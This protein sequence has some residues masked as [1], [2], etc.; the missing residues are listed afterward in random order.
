M[1]TDIDKRHRER[2]AEKARE[3]GRSTPSTSLKPLGSH[4]ASPFQQ[5][6][7]DPDAM[8]ISAGTSGSGNGK[9]REDWRK[10]LHSKCYSCGSDEHTIAKGYP[11]K[12][13][14]CQWCKKA[15][16]TSAVCMTRYLGQPRNDGPSQPQAVHA[17]IIPEASGSSS[18]SS[19]S[20][21]GAISEDVAAMVRQ[22]TEL[23]KALTEMRGDFS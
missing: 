6:S 10:A 8:D 12:R 4:Q 1:A 23:N 20:A 17:S 5:H 14:I 9:T 22:I 15:G 2:M 13:T 19:G 21:S 18:T 16:H 3:A 11:S 7:A